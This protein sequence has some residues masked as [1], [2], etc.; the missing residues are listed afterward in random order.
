MAKNGAMSAFP[1]RPCLAGGAGDSRSLLPF[2]LE[3]AY[4]KALPPAL[5]A[6]VETE[7]ASAVSMLNPSALLTTVQR[8]S[9]VTLHL[10]ATRAFA[11]TQAKPTPAVRLGFCLRFAPSA[12]LTT[13]QRFSGELF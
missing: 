3:P 11:P 6:I 7:F 5:Y 12:L 4:Q 8:F 9:A 2:A 10:F 13:V 1:A